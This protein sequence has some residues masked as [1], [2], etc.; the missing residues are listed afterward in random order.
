[1]FSVKIGLLH[2]F[3]FSLDKTT[4]AFTMRI[5]ISAS[6]DKLLVIVLA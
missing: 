3:L 4:A 2:T 6:S 5:L 1:M